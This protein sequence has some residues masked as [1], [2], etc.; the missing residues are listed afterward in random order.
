MGLALGLFCQDMCDRALFFLFCPKVFWKKKSGNTSFNL[1]R[2]WCPENQDLSFF[3]PK[4]VFQPNFNP[5]HLRN[6]D[7]S[8][9]DL[10]K[11]SQKPKSTQAQIFFFMNFKGK[12]TPNMNF[13]RQMKVFDTNII[14]F[15]SL[16]Q[17]QLHVSLSTIGIRQPLSL[18]LSLS[19]L[20]TRD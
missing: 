5:K 11:P 3:T 20:S 16:Y 9:F 19:P 1:P 14:R 2:L 6:R 18:S 10:K 15:G 12:K 4:L 13:P 8:I 7:K 17:C